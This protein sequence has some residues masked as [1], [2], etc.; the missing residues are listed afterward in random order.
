MIENEILET[1]FTGVRL[2]PPIVKRPNR[3]DLAG[4]AEKF[5]RNNLREPLSINRICQGIGTT[6]R[7][8]H[9]GFKERFGV[10]P[11]A[12]IQMKCLNEAR[13]ELLP[14]NNVTDTAF[15]CGFS[16]LATIF[17]MKFY[18]IVVIL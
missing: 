10:F 4:K 15:S 13:K 17:S 7:T 8:L 12:F 11:K 18:T 16:H 3:I 1:I 9:F 2:T 6:K 14:N 5:I